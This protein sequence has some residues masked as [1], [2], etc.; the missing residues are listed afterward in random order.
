MSVDHKAWPI[1]IVEDRYGG[2]YAGG[3]W[4]ALACADGDH[5]L[6]RDR[7]TAVLCAGPY[8]DDTDAMLFWQEPPDWIAVGA[9]PDQAL[10]ALRDKLAAPIGG[11]QP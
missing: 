4:L 11:Q 7:I 9:T 8:G 5:D 2:C 1:A 3:P 10:V 6:Y